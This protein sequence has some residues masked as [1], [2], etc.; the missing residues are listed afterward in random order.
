LP[1]KRPASKQ[2]AGLLLFRQRNG[3]EVLLG[4]PGGPFWRNKD[5]GAWSIPKGLIAPGEAPDVA[6][7]R[8]FAEETGHRPTGNTISLGT[9]K[10][11]GGKLVHIWAMEGDWSPAD[12]RSN[13]FELEWPPRSGRIQT[14]PEIDRA[15]W[16]GVAEARMRMLKGQVTFID[17]LLEAVGKAAHS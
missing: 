8:E 3:L 1:A 16:F 13:T 9:A 2:S 4:H 17:R 10:Q 7:H 14:F 5:Q 12:L 6:A 15:A 11:P